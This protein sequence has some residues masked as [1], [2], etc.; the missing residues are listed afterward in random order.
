ML[1]AIQR[2]IDHGQFILGPEV[3]E[4]EKQLA[5]YLGVKH[6]I[7]CA[8]GTDALMLAYMATMPGGQHILMPSFNYVA[9]AEAA[10]MTGN[11][12]EF[13]DVDYDTYNITPE[14]IAEQ[15][16][17][18]DH[19]AAVCAVSLFGL[20]PDLTEIKRICDK[21]RVILI[22]DNAQSLGAKHNGQHLTGLVG[23]TSFFPSKNLACMGDGGAVYTNDDEIA[24]KV[25]ALARHGQTGKKYHYQ[26]VG[27]N[28]RLDTIQAAILIE[29][30][31]ELDSVI[32]LQ[33]TVALDKCE[34]YGVMFNKEHTY[35]NFTIKVKN[36]NK[37]PDARVYYP[38]PLHKQEPYL[39]DV[40]LPITDKLCKE[41]IT[42]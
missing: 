16:R 41:V 37:Y 31:K 1:Q 28:S 42:L 33:K 32:E 39:S 3:Y 17:F 38:V 25:R 11:Y 15:L 18:D 29:R 30:L 6:V 20:K 23:T 2:V 36:R 8:N 21:Y 13:C 14:I 10:M 9:S 12:P 26:Y 4:F 34:K 24:A 7:T 22:E 19:I 27:M 40:H 5:D 35:N